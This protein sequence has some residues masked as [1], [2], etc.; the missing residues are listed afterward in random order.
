MRQLQKRYFKGLVPFTACKADPRFSYCA[1]VPEC[2]GDDEKPLPLLVV[3]HGSARTAESFRD[4]F[5]EFAEQRG[6]VILAPLFPVGS[7]GDED[8]YKLKPPLSFRYD[9]ALLHMVS[10]LGERYR[11]EQRFYLFGF[12]GGAQFAHR[13]WYLNASRVKAISVAAPGSVSLPVTGDELWELA[14]D[15][16]QNLETELADVPAQLLI[17]AEDGVSRSSTSKAEWPDRQESLKLLASHLAALGVNVQHQTVAE[18]AHDGFALI[19]AAQVFLA[20]QMR[21]QRGADSG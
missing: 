17:G 18:V 5:I 13:F 3:V 21:R 14:S 20:H 2:C 4:H 10:E 19:P 8:G 11:L 16:P 12:S 1:Y 7:A 6:C 9:Q 15:I